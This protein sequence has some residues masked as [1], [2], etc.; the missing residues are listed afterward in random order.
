[1]LLTTTMTRL[2]ESRSC[3]HL[4]C[5]GKTQVR[6]LVTL[7][8]GWIFRKFR[9]C[10]VEVGTGGLCSRNHGIMLA[11]IDSRI[12]L[13]N[14]SYYALAPGDIF[15]VLMEPQSS[16]NC[17][18]SYLQVA[19]GPKYNKIHEYPHI[20][21]RRSFPEGVL[22]TWNQLPRQH[23]LDQPDQKRL[24]SFKCSVHRFLRS[25]HWDWATDRL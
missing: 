14:S 12:M 17:A 22:D 4:N 19:S 2:A 1:M 10:V 13:V 21:V 5:I 16:E 24:Q 7:G 20:N 15:V 11:L 3:D 25:S 18:F 23:L 9:F 8:V 6:T